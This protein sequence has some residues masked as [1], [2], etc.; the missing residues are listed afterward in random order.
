MAAGG[1]LSEAG[2]LHSETRPQRRRPF[3]LYAILILLGTQAALTVAL[4]ALPVAAVVA[5]P[6][7]AW[8]ALGLEILVVP[9]AGAVALLALVTVV[10]LWRYKGWAWTL[11]MALLAL[12][13]AGDVYRYFFLTPRPLSMLINVLIVFYLNQREVRALFSPDAGGETGLGGAGTGAAAQSGAAR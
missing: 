6:G 5:A 11:M 12:W 4:A 1:D 13:M 3:G 2:P 9:V 8:Q 10:G 7:A